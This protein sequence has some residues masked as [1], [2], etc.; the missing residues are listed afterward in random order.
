MQNI[1]ALFEEGKV[2]IR[3]KFDELKEQLLA[4]LD[5]ERTNM[6]QQYVS[7]SGEMIRN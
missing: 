4:G 5:E 7:Y 3:E 2:K 1:K 6:E